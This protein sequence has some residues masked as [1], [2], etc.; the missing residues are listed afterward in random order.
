MRELLFGKWKFMEE[1]CEEGLYV[2]AA[3]E[4][5]MCKYCMTATCGERLQ[6]DEGQIVY[7]LAVACDEYGLPD[8]EI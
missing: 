2:H 8:D 6:T 5:E 3:G 7:C 1:T 4:R